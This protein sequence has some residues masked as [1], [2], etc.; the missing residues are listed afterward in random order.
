MMVDWVTAKIPVCHSEPIF[1]G[2]VV[3]YDKEGQKEFETYKHLPVEGSYSSKV[4]LRTLDSSTIQFSGN[5]V[6]FLQGHNLFGSTDIVALMTSTLEIVF[7]KLDITPSEQDWQVIR[8]GNYTISRVDL[9]AMYE[10][11]T[12]ADVL[13]WIRAA[14]ISSRSRHK[15]AGLQ[16]GDTIYWGKHS[17]RWTL[18]A[19]AKGQEILVP[20]HTL[21]P[22]LPYCEKLI[23][24]A[25]NKLRIE[26]TLRGAELRKEG[27][28]TAAAFSN[29]SA[30]EIF[31]KYLGKITLS[32]NFNL[33]TET[34][35]GLPNSLR[36]TYVLWE[37]GEDLRSKLSKNTYYRH[38]R[39]LM[40]WGVDIAI[41]PTTATE[42]EVSL[43]HALEARVIQCPNF[44]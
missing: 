41:K 7:G 26:L 2:K 23:S 14:A 3:S 17:R 13:A 43:R 39:E 33:T 37:R 15:S 40:A 11:R 8:S 27:I 1:G 4:S 19:Y 5:P 30:L 16:R 35:D 36:C 24:W 44:I 28:Y 6:K 34:L 32:D 18:K 12:L 25:Q 31:Q 38:R 21:S 22:L 20:A 29:A 10:L 42:R 9:T